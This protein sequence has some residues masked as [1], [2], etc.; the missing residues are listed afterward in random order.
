MLGIR[1][2]GIGMPFLQRVVAAASL[3]GGAGHGD[4]GHGDAGH[5][6]AGHGDALPTGLWAARHGD[7]GHKNGMTTVWH[8]KLEVD[9]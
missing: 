5:G 4:A 3:C 9:L 1:K 8:R 7:A 2:P 6:D